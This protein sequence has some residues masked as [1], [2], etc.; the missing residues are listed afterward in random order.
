MKKM[1]FLQVTLGYQILWGHAYVHHQDS[2]IQSL[3]THDTQPALLLHS[4]SV[5]PSACRYH[6][7]MSFLEIPC[8]VYPHIQIQCRFVGLPNVP[9]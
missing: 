6:E 9:W 4:N 5:L 1:I 8:A 7:E 3:V 2:K